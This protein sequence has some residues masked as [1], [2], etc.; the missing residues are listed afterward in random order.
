MDAHGVPRAIILDG[1]IAGF[2]IART[3]TPA[4]SCSAPRRRARV[5]ASTVF[6]NNSAFDD[7]DFAANAAISTTP[8]PARSC[9]ASPAGRRRRSTC[10]GYSKGINGIMVACWTRTRRATWTSSSASATRPTPKAG[11]RARAGRGRRSC[12]GA[13]QQG[14]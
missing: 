1:S 9:C 3:A 10:T 11:R 2:G 5:T 6:Y 4:Y 7:H 13:G 14:R 12:P 8:S